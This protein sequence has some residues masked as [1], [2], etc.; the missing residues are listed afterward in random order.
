MQGTSPFVTGV[1]ETR[2]FQASMAARNVFNE[3][4]RFSAVTADR[5]LSHHLPG[6]NRPGRCPVHHRR[7]SVRRWKAGRSKRTEPQCRHAYRLQADLHTKLRQRP[8][9]SGK[10]TRGHSQ[11]RRSWPFAHWRCGRIRHA[12]IVETRWKACHGA[13]KAVEFHSVKHQATSE[14]RALELPSSFSELFRM[15]LSTKPFD[16]FRY[17]LK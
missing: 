15:T 7:Q 6:E 17:T 13:S 8:V 1:N 9:T 14:G 2:C 11:G 4:I 10:V 3:K 12:H 16:E 5:A